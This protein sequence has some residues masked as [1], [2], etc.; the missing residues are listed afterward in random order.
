MYINEWKS[1]SNKTI[2]L[3]DFHIINFLEVL[4][5]TGPWK[6]KKCT[7]FSQSQPITL[8]VAQPR[9]PLQSTP[10]GGCFT[11]VSRALQNNL[12][13]IYNAK[14][15][16]F[17]ENFKL[18][19]CTCAQS[20]ALD[21]CAKFQLEILIRCTIS[22]IHKFRE[23]ILESLRNVSETPPR[24][25]SHQ[26]YFLIKFQIQSLWF[27]SLFGGKVG[28]FQGIMPSWYDGGCRSH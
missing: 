13:K 1:G 14:N 20:L 12:A 18:K 7:K 8:L 27:K 2:L 24:L 21:T 15:H 17:S 19:L 28:C 10:P 22:V 6:K 4:W 23:N 25:L 16:I 5:N 9:G 26:R 3:T 11:N